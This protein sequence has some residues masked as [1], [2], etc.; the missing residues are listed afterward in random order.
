MEFDNFDFGQKEADGTLQ[1]V[2]LHEMGHVIGIGSI[3]GT[4]HVLA[5]AGTAN[6]TFSGSKADK[7]WAK[8]SKLPPKHLPVENHGGDG[9]ADSHWRETVFGNELM[10]GFISGITLPLRKM[11]VAS[12]ADLGYAER[13]PATTVR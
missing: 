2:I 5:G 1:S 6:P 10:T 7:E 11:T 8:L 12:L 3:W 13:R 4:K 9:T